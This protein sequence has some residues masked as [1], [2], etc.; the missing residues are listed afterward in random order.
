MNLSGFSGQSAQ[1]HGISLCDRAV[2]LRSGSRT[3]KDAIYGVLILSAVFL[4]GCVNNAQISEKIAAKFTTAPDL[5]LDPNL[6]TPLAALLTL[7]TDIPTR[8]TLDITRGTHTHSI[9]FNEFHTDHSLPVL[10]F[11]PATSYR[12]KVHIYSRDGT[13]TTYKHSLGISTE[14]LP[15]GFPRIVV[16]NSQPQNM[17]PG[18]TLLEIIPEGTNSEFGALIVI[19]NA[20]GELV[21]Y[22]IGSRYTDVRQSRDGN[23]LFLEG[24][25][26]VKMD[27]LGNRVHEWKAMGKSRQHSIP[28]PVAAQSFHHEAFPMPNG[29]VLVLSIES[30]R[31][32]NYPTKDS[33]PSAPHTT[34]QV[35]GDVV[36]EFAP[37][38]KIV[39]QWSLLDIL[40]PY[41]IGYGSL[42]NYW[43]GFFNTKTRDWSHANAVIYDATDDAIIVS[44]RHQD[45]VVK[46]SRK[47]G[48]LIWILAPHDNWDAKRFGKYL[49]KPVNDV[50]FFFPFHAHA[51]MLLPSGHLMLYDNGNYRASPFSPMQPA[52][53]NFSRAVE[54]AIDQQSMEVKLVWE[55]GEFAKPR[56]FCGA[57]GDADLLSGKDNVLITHGNI[58]SGPSKYEARVLEV[59]HTTPAREVFNLR[60]FN[61]EPDPD[62]GWRVYRSERIPSLYPQ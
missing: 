40:D 50:K 57:L 60:V 61:D 30:R 13:K 59:T 10:G 31:Y 49:L 36:V 14:P 53:E 7:S 26:F 38:G 52:A 6:N 42:G 8:V 33:D 16:D 18:Y 20:H 41:R 58:V 54:Y 12:V 25:K 48:K 29:N 32:D 43:D 62:A 27:M 46:F 51:P 24:G 22:Q 2:S 11:Q 56:Y 39:H 55:Y 23:L 37:D 21:W 19:V 28:T 34:A 35:A 17:A 45:T 15:N 9:H 44:L 4:A 1:R 3:S 47:S 5:E